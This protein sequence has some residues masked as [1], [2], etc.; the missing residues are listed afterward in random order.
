[1][2]KIQIDF[3][4]LRD[5]AHF[6]SEEKLF[7]FDL[8][9]TNNL[10]QDIFNGTP[11]C[12]LI[13][14]YRGA[15]KSSFIESIKTIIDK[16]QE[17]IK[18]KN[19]AKENNK[20]KE[21]KDE[22]RK[23][24]V[25]VTTNFS[26]YQSQ[27]YLLR[28]LIR[29][30][31]LNVSKTKKYEELKIKE[32]NF[33]KNGIAHLLDT[34]Y[35]KTF[36]E[37]VSN[38]SQGSKNELTV[39]KEVD[40]I[41]FFGSI[42]IILVIAFN[43]IFK[44]VP[45]TVVLN[46]IGIIGAAIVTFQEV[47][48]FNTSNTSISIDQQ[49]LNRKSLYDEEIA[50]HHFFNLLD[51]LTENNFKVVFVLD[52]LD[53]VDDEDIDKLLR[54]M[55]SL[56]VSGKAS[57]IVV[58]GQQ[59]FYEYYNSKGIDDAIISSIFSKIIHVPLLSRIEFQE[60]FKKIII[61]NELLSEINQQTVE[62]YIDSLVF[63]SNRTSRKFISLIRQDLIWENDLAYI[64]LS[65]SD[66]LSIY[67]KL[68]NIVERI[69]DEEISVE[70]S[71]IALRDYFVMQI[72]IKSHFILS[73]RKQVFSEGEVIEPYDEKNKMPVNSY[74]S[75]LDRYL[76]AFLRE[77]VTEKIIQKEKNPISEESLYSFSYKQKIISQSIKLQEKNIFQNIFEFRNIL[78]SAYRHLK[79][80]DSELTNNFTL[81]DFVT[82]FES[83]G[84]FKADWK[85]DAEVKDVFN[86]AESLMGDEKA[87]KRVI[88]ILNNNNISLSKLI[89]KV[90]E[91]FGKD[92]AQSHF[93]KFGYS[94]V[95]KP[96]GDFNQ[97]DL[98]LSKV[99]SP[100]LYLIFEFKYRKKTALPTREMILWAV[101]QLNTL[102]IHDKKDKDLGYYFLVIFTDQSNAE[103]NKLQF[104]FRELLE[105]TI[106]D[107]LL[108][109]RIKFI[110]VFT[111]TLIQIEESFNS[112]QKNYIQE[113][114]YFKFST[115]NTPLNFPNRN[116]CVFE[117]VFNLQKSDFE[118]SITPQK[119]EF[120]RFGIQ[121]SDSDFFPTSFKEERHANKNYPYIVLCVGEAQNNDQ[122]GL[123]W[124]F[125][126][127]I[128]FSSYVDNEDYTISQ[129]YNGNSVELKISS[130]DLSEV[131]F[132]LEQNGSK[133]G[134]Q[135]FDLRKFKYCKFSAWCDQRHYEL[136]AQI[137][138]VHKIT[139]V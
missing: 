108:S 98:I 56:L 5:S 26:K 21:K 23:E 132:S 38:N 120:W 110:P 7:H 117:K 15:G 74:K 18:D 122:N 131:L 93:E 11:T 58:A 78:Y 70:V 112:F 73:N 96:I 133:M 47:M 119:T 121:L 41:K 94:I 12:Y 19:L 77:L 87:Q 22:I 14:G 54:E 72:F 136:G 10:I 135:I 101:Q 40:Y 126:N 137:K 129:V 25:F 53:K 24:I 80:P 124:N 100:F 109:D 61:K 42:L 32:K 75:F 90:L 6:D 27:T 84:V 48:K 51:E 33:K 95:N 37:V 46:F 111:N 83:L 97:S 43:S 107:K 103:F 52:E 59:L 66:D 49:E 50:D 105:N 125:P 63:E 13:S 82:K 29:G 45:I 35:E 139:L 104:K 62:H 79:Y 69:D 9:L 99:K 4:K 39:K 88:D 34:L 68:L 17:S 106:D 16:R 113:E 1:M 134:E 81:I 91:F 89:L 28:K 20:D 67:S 44:W 36:Y 64:E 130:T 116:D 3:N 55:K 57:F 30:L 92:K 118:I 128:S 115:Q 71:E 8:E 76:K 102:N 2:T 86:N 60:L 85:S 65:D 127:K 31:Y 138:A 114:D 123:R